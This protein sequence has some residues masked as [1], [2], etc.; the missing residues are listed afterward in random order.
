MKNP[1][2][3]L[4][5]FVDYLKKQHT[6]IAKEM[7]DVLTPED[8]KAK[9]TEALASTKGKGILTFKEILDS[10]KHEG[11]TNGRLTVLNHLIVVFEKQIN[12]SEE[13]NGSV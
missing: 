13:V 9:T 5:D 8:V 2:I 1:V 6:E 3:D 12:N 11:Y 7:K 4:K 10:I